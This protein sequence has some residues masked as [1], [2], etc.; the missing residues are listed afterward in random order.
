LK[1]CEACH[2]GCCR[3]FFPDITGYDIIKIIESS[4]LD[5][6]FFATAQ[7]V[8][9]NYLKIA[10]GIKPLF[11]FTDSGEKQYYRFCLKMEESS[12]FPDSYKCIF[13]NEL[14]AKKEGSKLYDGIIARCSIYHARPLTCRTFPAKFHPKKKKGMLIDPNKSFPKDKNPA[15]KLCPRPL[16]A[17][18][19]QG[20]Q[21][22]TL[23][24]LV[25]YDY[26]MAFFLELS[27]KWNE[28]PDLSDYFA[29]FMIKKYQNRITLN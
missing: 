13:L 11:A 28:K 12:L 20:N 4:G 3:R 10:L 23:N 6:N 24:N 14:D 2:G 5:I 16:I 21:A 15:Y 29:E 19:S 18:D 27:E 7:P 1:I 17:E 9:E 26:E 22:E 25:L 8:D